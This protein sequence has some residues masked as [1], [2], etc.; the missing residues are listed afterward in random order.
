MPD[1]PLADQLLENPL[2]SVPKTISSQSRLNCTYQRRPAQHVLIAL[3]FG[4]RPQRK[5][6]IGPVATSRSCSRTGRINRSS[7]RQLLRR[8]DFGAV[9]PLF[10]AG[11]ANN[12]SML[13][14]GLKFL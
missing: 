3:G 4:S 8:D 13:A 9:G 12:S 6:L 11:R 2:P 5:I 10:P 14:F 7:V 1:R